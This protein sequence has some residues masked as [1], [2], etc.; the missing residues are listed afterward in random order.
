[1]P[2]AAI[3]TPATLSIKSA[4]VVPTLSRMQHVPNVDFV[5]LNYVGNMAPNPFWPDTKGPNEPVPFFYNG[6]SRA[7]E[8]VVQA[9]A[10]EGSMLPI[11]S[12]GIN[13]SYHTEFYG[14]A[15]RCHDVSETLRAAIEASIVRATRPHNTSCHA[16]GFLAWTPEDSNQSGSGL[17]PFTN[18]RNK[19]YSLNSVPL[20]ARHHSSPA[21]IY[22]A[23]MPEMMVTQ[24]FGDHGVLQTCQGLLDNESGREYAFNNSAMLQCDLHN[25]T[26][27]AEVKFI[28]G[29]QHI[30]VTPAFSNDAAMNTVHQVYGPPSYPIGRA[31]GPD[32]SPLTLNSE[33]TCTFNSSLISTLAYQAVFQ[34]FTELLVGSIF[35]SET[36]FNPAIDTAVQDTTLVDSPELSFLTKATTISSWTGQFSLQQSIMS[37]N[38]TLFEGIW[39]NQSS[40]TSVPLRNMMEQLF[41][42]VTISLMSSRKLQYFTSHSCPC[43]LLMIF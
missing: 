39:K 37:S 14:P 6:P 43:A 29:D 24:S 30:A 28:N 18:H 15:V 21:S 25:T 19:S 10:A 7:V 38:G 41:Q 20:S 26:Y 3:V 2:I 4:P 40:S 33:R 16:Y 42:N 36:D 8:N 12:P 22:L 5:N 27:S 32:C 35:V 11:S 13:S 31:S 9:V 23:A 17:L 34:A 1:M